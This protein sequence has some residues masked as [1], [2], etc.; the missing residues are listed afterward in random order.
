MVENNNFA[1]CSQHD[2]PEV[3]INLSCTSLHGKSLG[4]RFLPIE[5]AG[6]VFESEDYKPK[7]ETLYVPLK[8]DVL[9]SMQNIEQVSFSEGS[10]FIGDDSNRFSRAEQGAAVHMWRYSEMHRKLYISRS[11]L[12]TRLQSYEAIKKLLSDM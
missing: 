9:V 2:E 5:A 7:G 4:R 12:F 8:N 6:D 10:F 1:P 11:F 3:P